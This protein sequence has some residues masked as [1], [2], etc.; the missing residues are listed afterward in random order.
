M[1]PSWQEW[2]ILRTRENVATPA[3]PSVAAAASARS[4]PPFLAS[5][6]AKAKDVPEP[7]QGAPPSWADVLV[8]CK[9]TGASTP[10][11]SLLYLVSGVLADD[12]N[13]DKPTYFANASPITSLPSLRCDTAC[14]GGGQDQD[15]PGRRQPARD[16]R[17]VFPAS[18]SHVNNALILEHHYYHVNAVAGRAA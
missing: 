11:P 6:I 2:K 13:D 18:C 9:T 3:P 15:G 14:G 4:L 12:K 8:H 7:D 10:N 5:A 16:G 17:I 1:T